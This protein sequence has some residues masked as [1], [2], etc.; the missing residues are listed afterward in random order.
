[1]GQQQILF[2]ILG[3]CII[4]VAISTGL[5]VLQ[6]DPGLDHRQA[7]YSELKELASKA[8]AYRHISFEQGG[9]D[10]TFIGLTSTPQG[11]AKLT[12]TWL[13]PHAEYSIPTSGNSRSVQ[14][15]AVGHLPGNDPRKPIKMMM[16]VFA[17]S[18]SIAVLN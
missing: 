16:T 9:G 12:I 15:M 5:I 17:E 11:I 14:I 4:G 3:V 2:L 10:G 18:T 6:S 8:Q 7:I 1:M 13:R